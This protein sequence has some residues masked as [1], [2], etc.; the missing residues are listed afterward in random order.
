MKVR[1]AEVKEPIDLSTWTVT[2]IPS[3]EQED[4]SSCG[5]FVLMVAIV[6][7][8]MFKMIATHLTS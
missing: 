3:G 1:S 5:I 4:G 2:T 6:F 8:H 7:Y